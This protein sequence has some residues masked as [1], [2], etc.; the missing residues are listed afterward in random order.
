VSIV[1]EESESLRNVTNSL[2]IDGC[3]CPWHTDIYGGAELKT[4]SIGKRGEEVEAEVRSK[5][6]KEQCCKELKQITKWGKI[7]I[8][9]C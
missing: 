8:L 5:P 2:D 7:Y 6:C 3:Q 1:F 9:I 4:W